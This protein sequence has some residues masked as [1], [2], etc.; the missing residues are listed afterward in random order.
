[1][2]GSL[3]EYVAKVKEGAEKEQE[4][5]EREEQEIRKNSDCLRR[6]ECILQELDVLAL[7]MEEHLKKTGAREKVRRLKQIKEELFDQEEQRQDTLISLAVLES[8][9]AALEKEKGKLRS[10]QRRKRER[11]NVLRQSWLWGW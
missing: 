7:G 3:E 10:G 11:R 8:E 9:G 5:L 1:M 2:V 6:S 4:L